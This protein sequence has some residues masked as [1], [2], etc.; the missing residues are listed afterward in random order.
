MSSVTLKLFSSNL[1]FFNVYR[2]PPA[3]TKTRKPV[4]F[5]DFLSD[6]DTLL[7]LAATIRH[8]FLITGDFNFHLDNPD[9]SHVKQFIF[10]LDSTN[11]TQ[12][13]SFPTHQDLHT[14][15]LVITASSSSLSP[16]IDHS[17]VS[18]CDYS[19]IFSTLTISL[20]PPPPLSTFSFRCL[21][22]ISISKFKHD[23]ANSRLI[24]H[25]PTDLYDLVYSYNTT[26]SSLLDKH[27][28]LKT[29]T[30]R[31]KT[32]NPW[33]TPALAKLK[34]TR[35]HLEKVWLRIRSLQDLQPLRIATNA[36]HSSIVHNLGQ[37][38]LQLIAY[39]F[40]HLKFLQALELH[41]QASTSQTYFSTA[42]Q[43]RLQISPLPCLPISFPTKYSNFIP[44]STNE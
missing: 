13:V 9:D 8:E 23:I 27:A 39:L 34:S 44:L 11:P 5:S 32:P 1:T 25:P 42:I 40:L 17:P 18:P 15:D 37:K 19:H 22:S 10:E 30:I 16:I 31:A 38:T 14:L 2:P 4:S 12:Y 43:H 41:Q 20:L 21:K 26:L 28:P 29:K 24:T 35:R 7:S 33:F 6:L 36:Y 3:T